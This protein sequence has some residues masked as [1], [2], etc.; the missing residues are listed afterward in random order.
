MELIHQVT[1]K[2]KWE[3]RLIT[4]WWGHK[5][6]KKLVRAQARVECKIIQWC[7]L[8]NRAWTQSLEIH[9]T[10]SLKPN[11]WIP[12]VLLKTL[13]EWKKTFHNLVIKL[14]TKPT[15]AQINKTAGVKWDQEMPWCSKLPK[16]PTSI[17]WSI[18]MI[19]SNQFL[20]RWQWIQ[21]WQETR[22]QPQVK[23]EG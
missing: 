1:T 6:S 5:I 17:K 16:L 3:I 4:R 21:L 15:Q 7:K 8:E 23:E 2:E 10:L 22:D 9:I 20:T 13:Q 11:T 12:P 18:Q 19:K 14:Q